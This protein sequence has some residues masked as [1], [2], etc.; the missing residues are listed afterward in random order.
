M[1]Y[2][3]TYSTSDHLPILSDFILN[4]ENVNTEEV[5]GCTYPSAIN[6]SNS[7]TLDDGSCEFESCDSA[8]E[9]GYEQGLIDA[10]ES[11]NCPGDLTNDL[12]VSTQD[13]LELLTLFGNQCE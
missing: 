8:Y 2:N 4:V 10:S 11:N 7:A 6:F 9:T 12:I 5:L 13:L 3:D 1:E